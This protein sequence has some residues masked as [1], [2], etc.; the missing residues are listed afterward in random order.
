M[1]SKAS[2]FVKRS[3]E[4]AGRFLQSAVIV[5]DRAHLGPRP[6]PAVSPS[7]RRAPGSESRSEGPGDN[8]G[9][10]RH[11]LDA[12][13][14]ID[15]FA[16]L[17]IVCA[18]LK[19]ALLTDP[20]DDGES[21]DGL[22]ELSDR[23]D[24]ATQ[25]ADIVIL[26]WNIPNE[27][28]PGENALC[29]IRAILKTDDSTKKAER[30]DSRRLRLIAIYTGEENLKSIAEES[31]RLLAGLPLEPLVKDTYSV[32]AGPV[33]I[34]VYGKGKPTIQWNDS[35]RRVNE[36]ELPNRLRNDFAEM[37][38]GL[39]SN[40]AL[41]S[42]SAIR[43][44]THRILRRFDRALDPAYVSHRAMMVPPADAEGH[45]IPL[46]VSEIEGVLSDDLEIIELVGLEAI[47]DWL[48][49]INPD[50]AQLEKLQ[51][52]AGGFKE[53]LLRLLEKGL[54][55][56]PE[57]KHGEWLSLRKKLKKG[58]RKKA[59]VLTQLLDR[60]DSTM[61]YRF[62]LLTSIRSRYDAPP[63]RLGLGS[64]VHAEGHGYLFCIQP[65]C[66]S[67]R[68]EGARG[69][70]FLTL[71]EREEGDSF[72]LVVEDGSAW[73]RLHV[74]RKAFDLRLI[75][76]KPGE[77]G[78]VAGHRT[79]DGWV[80]DCSDESARVRWLADLKPEFAFRVLNEFVGSVSRV[81]STESEWLRRM[82]K[83]Q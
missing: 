77:S 23:T 47:G 1:T 6:K 69:F 46:I 25:R 45:P 18:V 56:D 57:D 68:L 36:K 63:P 58:D 66:D 82:A 37:T 9:D 53:S 34:G 73:K 24:K 51:I 42:L 10:P 26:D 40:V 2:G 17:G 3:R 21:P 33:T 30:D 62:A 16:G 75:S 60:T 79:Q 27:E 29:L 13:V 81:G 70:P 55:E 71:I 72:D 4:V 5:D 14:L 80:F 67:A 78:A 15:A 32:S 7:R 19:P 50:E 61:D 49:D 52:D 43:T 35:S 39:L 64:I 41:E 28:K 83:K 11:D 59:G 74:S 22:K 8:L 48:H 76:M 12:K 44:N 38:R 20:E 31:A 65:A 54:G